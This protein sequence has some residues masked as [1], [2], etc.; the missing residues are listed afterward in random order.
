MKIKLTTKN[1]NN[2]YH[3]YAV[4]DIRMN[5]QMLSRLIGDRFHD[6]YEKTRFKYKAH[7]EL[8]IPQDDNVKA[9]YFCGVDRWHKESAGVAFFPC[10]GQNIQINNEQF[11]LKIIDACQMYFQNH[12]STDEP[13]S[14]LFVRYMKDNVLS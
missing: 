7:V 8:E 2:C 12:E 14:Q 1:P 4:R 11:R 9:Y 5:R 3:L 10:D 6:V 13:L